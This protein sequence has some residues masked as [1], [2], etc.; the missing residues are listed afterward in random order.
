MGLLRGMTAGLASRRVRFRAWIVSLL[1]FA[2]MLAAPGVAESATTFHGK[3]VIVTADV[4]SPKHPFGA[5]QVT[6][7]LQVGDRLYFL[8]GRSSYRFKTGQP[9][10]VVGTLKGRS[11]HVTAASATGAAP[12]VATTGTMNVLVILVD[13]SGHPADATTPAQAQQQVGPTDNSWYQADSYGA[14]GT[15]ATATNWLTIAD[16]FQG[17]TTCDYSTLGNSADQAATGAGYNVSAYTNRMYYF[18]YDGICSWGGLAYVG[19]NQTWSNGEMD[20]RVTIHEL[21]HNLGLWHSHSYPC[22]N[23]SGSYVTLG[24]NCTSDEYGNP[25]STMGAA[26]S[27]TGMFTAPQQSALGWFAGIHNVATVQANGTYTLTPL[28]SA[29][30]GTQALFIPFTATGSNVWIEYRQPMGDD[31]Q[32]GSAGLTAGVLI[33]YNSSTS[34]NLLDG[35]PAT[36]GNFAD[37]PLPPNTSWTDSIDGVTVKVGAESS[38]GASVTVSFSGPKGVPGPLAAQFIVPS[39]L[40]TASSPTDPYKL[41][42][43]QGSCSAGSTYAV[44]ESVNGGGT[45]TVFSGTATSHTVNLL[46]GNVYTFSVACGG[47]ASTTTFRLSGFQ[48]TSA[49][50]SGTWTPTSFAGAWGGAAKYATAKGASAT[51][52]CLCE[53]IAWVTDEDTTHGSANVY[54]DGVL[55]KTVNTQSS[56]AKNRIVVFKVGWATDGTHTVKIVNLATSGHPRLNVDGFLTRTSS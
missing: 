52:T 30:G 27:M 22:T 4:R 29:A 34:S 51:F 56:A 53:A 14:E 17:D 8:R 54:V 44:S 12:V 42:W 31:A 46:P 40:S 9:V 39:T 36:G 37:A 32:V 49:S 21:G 7:A 50:Y 43:T 26:F 38:S 3:F 35:T 48:E 55:K 41:S 28:E 11:I 47:G 18:P 6:Y 16:P 33:N 5:D 10:D 23:T 2:T 24:T 15:S 45:V 25:Y 19:G 20:G 13:W 1:L